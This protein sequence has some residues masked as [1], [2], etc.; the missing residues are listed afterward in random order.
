MSITEAAN[1]HL[2][3]INSSWDYYPDPNHNF[4]HISIEKVEQYISDYEKQNDTKV[5]YTPL[6]FLNKQEI[7]RETKLTF[8]AY[9]LFAKDL[10]IISDLQIGRFKSPTKIIDSVNLDTD[11]FTELDEIIA[12]I[13]KHLI[14]EFIITGNPQREERYDYPLE[15]I[16]EIVINMLIHRDY[17]NSSGSIIKIYDDRIEFFNPGGLFGGL[18][19]EE[20]LKFN[21]QPQARNKL[22]AKAFKEIG[23]VER[24]G[25]GMKRIFTICKNY[26]IVPPQI[27]IKLNTFELILY[28]DKLSEGINEGINVLYNYIKKNPNKRVSQIEKDL[29]IPQKTLERW[30]KSLK[31]KNKI[32]FKGSKKTGGYYA[33]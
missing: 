33:L 10:C 18:T 16:R 7:I 8:G 19:K 1:E 12:F 20:L 5:E 24:Y 25:S 26:G 15:A 28:K 29:E 17:R 32:I 13:K 14:V 27:N 6:E 31:N 23:K 11:I 9:L 30:I 22:I 3:T 4:E 21:Y 2:R